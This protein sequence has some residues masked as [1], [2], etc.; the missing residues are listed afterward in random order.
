V[1]KLSITHSLDCLYIKDLISLWCTLRVVTPLSSHSQSSENGDMPR[2]PWKAEG[3][4]YEDWEFHSSPPRVK[5]GEN[6]LCESFA[7]KLLFFTLGRFFHR[8]RLAVARSPWTEHKFLPHADS[9]VIPI[10]H[11]PRATIGVSHFLHGEAILLAPLFPHSPFSEEL[12]QPLFHVCSWDIY[13][14]KWTTLV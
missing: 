2:S 13:H 10:L 8:W 9:R 4:F 5:N 14:M 12:W 7:A 6:F 3:P 11:S 1:W